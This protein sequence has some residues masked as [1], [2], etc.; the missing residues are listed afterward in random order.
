MPHFAPPLA[1]FVLFALAAPASAV[2]FASQVQPILVKH[3]AQCHGDEKG[4]GKLRLHTAE[5]IAASPHDDLLVAGKPEASELFERITLPAD[6][7]KRMPKGA[8]PLPAE[9]IELLK[10]WIAEGAKLT[11][12]DVPAPAPAETEPRQTDEQAAAAAAEETK[13][14]AELAAELAAVQPA[15][16]EA[17]AAVTQAGGTV[18]PLFAG[19]PLLDV[20][21]AQAGSPPGDEA[22]AALAGIADQVASLNL[23]GAQATAA[24]LAP[25][26]KLTHLERLHLERSNIDAAGLAHLAGKRH[27]AYLNLYD[28]PLGDDALPTL[29][30]LPRLRRL[31]LWN[32]QVSY[33]GA[34]G[35]RAGN[36]QLAVDMGWNHPRVV[37]ERLAGDVERLKATVAEATTQVD[38]LQ[39]QLEAAKTARDAAAEQLA[40]IEAE[41]AAL[42]QPAP[43]ATPAAESAETPAAE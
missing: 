12:A 1:A 21:F 34:M 27:L 8:D 42:D 24:G 37:R 31:F 11:S 29:A 41:I 7:K 17:I 39:K 9:T 18:L 20:S 35:L 43:E 5:A 6:D 3:C 40:T 10:Q 33:D 26:A 23:A 15:S 13:L 38:E 4:L 16:A 19:S 14:V 25:L 2:D 36:P 32:T 28:A 22:I 30:S